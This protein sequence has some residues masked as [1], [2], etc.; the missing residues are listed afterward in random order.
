MFPHDKRQ[1]ATNAYLRF[2]FN[3]FFLS[4]SYKY[5]R[6]HFS[7]TRYITPTMPAVG[8]FYIFVSSL[9]S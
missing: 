2:F 4:R 6:F 3:L 5:Y 7:H 8:G 1:P 9:S